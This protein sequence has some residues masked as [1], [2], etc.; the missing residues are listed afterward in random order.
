MLF[1]KNWYIRKMGFRIAIDKT[2]WYIKMPDNSK[3]Y[4]LFSLTNKTEKLGNVTSFHC[5]WLKL[6]CYRLK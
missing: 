3:Y 1:E 5:L 6:A 4:L 2:L